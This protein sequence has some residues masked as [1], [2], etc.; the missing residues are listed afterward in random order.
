MHSRVYCVKCSSSRG[1]NFEL[2]TIR[3]RPIFA[4][5]ANIMYKSKI[6]IRHT[7]NVKQYSVF[8]I[9]IT[10]YLYRVIDPSTLNHAKIMNASK[11]RIRYLATEEQNRDLE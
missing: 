2:V 1:N 3:T 5:C 6:R 8:R 9:R 10:F 4:T 7:V 11:I